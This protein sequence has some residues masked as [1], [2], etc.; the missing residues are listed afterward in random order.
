MVRLFKVVVSTRSRT[1]PTIILIKTGE[2]LTPKEI[3]ES[4]E[5]NPHQLKTKIFMT[6]MNKLIKKGFGRG[7]LE[8]ALSKPYNSKMV[9]D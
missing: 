4:I 6:R 3:E 9:R 2:L 8:E 5:F 1:V 7:A